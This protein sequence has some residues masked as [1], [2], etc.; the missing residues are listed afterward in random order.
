MA[1]VVQRSVS[2]PV[3]TFYSQYDSE[4]VCVIAI[5]I[6]SELLGQDPCL[7]AILGV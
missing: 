3:E 4:A 6:C 5:E 2:N 1:E 7:T